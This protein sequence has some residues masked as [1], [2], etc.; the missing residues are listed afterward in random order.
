MIVVAI[1]GI[2]AAIA[3]PQYQDYVTRSQ[4]TRVMSEAGQLRTAVE[5]CILDGKSTPGD[6]DTDSNNCKIGATASNLLDS[7][8]GPQSGEDAV[9]NA[10][11]PQVPEELV[12]KSTITA[13]FG[14]NA[15]V[16]IKGNQLVWQRT[17]QGSWC[18]QT[19]VAKKY[20]P[21]GCQM[22]ITAG[23]CAGGGGG[24]GE[25]GGG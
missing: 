8:D 2:L 22:D 1:I 9:A 16:A 25:G 4:V 7:G 6:P 20:R 19:N 15:A 24:G 23:S 10:G 12:T 14:S 3:I 11:F 17:E 13:K 21:S 18:C 5:T